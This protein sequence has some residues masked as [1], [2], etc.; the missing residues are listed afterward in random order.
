MKVNSRSFITCIKRA[1]KFPNMIKHTRHSP[2][3]NL[4]GFLEWYEGFLIPTVCSYDD[5]TSLIRK[6]LLHH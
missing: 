6:T 2:L 3:H 5:L 4:F 1:P